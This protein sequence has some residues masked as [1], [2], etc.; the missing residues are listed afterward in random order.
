MPKIKKVMHEQ[1]EAIGK[2]SAQVENMN[3]YYATYGMPLFIKNP[4]LQGVI[5]LVLGA[6]YVQEKYGTKLEAFLTDLDAKMR[7]DLEKVG[8]KKLAELL[9]NVPDY[10]IQEYVKPTEEELTP[11]E[12]ILED[13]ETHSQVIN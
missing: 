5:P 12:D 8:D 9:K 6:E 3:A 13:K 10:P 7:K 1:M 11:E 2:L 4:E